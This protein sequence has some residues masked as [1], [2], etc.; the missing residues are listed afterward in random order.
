M[1]DSLI[2]AL[3]VAI[4][5]SN[6]PGIVEYLTV[7]FTFVLTLVAVFSFIIAKRIKISE[8][9]K[10]LNDFASLTGKL[11]SKILPGVLAKFE[12][13]GFAPEGITAKMAEITS[14]A[15]FNIESPKALNDYGIEILKGSGVDKII[16]ENYVHFVSKIDGDEK[17]KNGLVVEERAFYAINE[18]E[19]NDMLNAVQVYLY[20][21]S[22]MAFETIALIG[23]I[24]L[25]D[26][27]LDDN[28]TIAPEPEPPKV[29]QNPE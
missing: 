15:A 12:V 23:S 26:K 27:Y 14:S 20:E 19:D 2:S 8:Y 3:T 22:R 28:P 25:R 16:D 10:P 29:S 6:K 1:N 13:K 11:A 5:E 4:E 21:N 7:A 24:Y 17:P 9:L 18:E